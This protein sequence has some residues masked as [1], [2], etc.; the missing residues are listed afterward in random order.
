MT[1]CMVILDLETIDQQD[2]EWKEISIDFELLNK[3]GHHECHNLAQDLP[4]LV[5]KRHIQP[6][7]PAH[8]FSLITFLSNEQEKLTKSTSLQM[9]ANRRQELIHAI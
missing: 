4:I 8:I 1:P 5:T 2:S 3:I 9:D 6:M 7:I